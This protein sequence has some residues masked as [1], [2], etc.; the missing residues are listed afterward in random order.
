[1]TGK[2]WNRIRRRRPLDIPPLSEVV[3]IISE[4]AWITSAPVNNNT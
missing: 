2:S 1:M 3:E 4:K